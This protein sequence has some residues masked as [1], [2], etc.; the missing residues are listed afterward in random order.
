M[1]I[2]T[3]PGQNNIQMRDWNGAGMLAVANDGK[4][5]RLPL[6]VNRAL[7]TLCQIIL[8]APLILMWAVRR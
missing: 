7:W 2:R 3:G 6:P 5:Y 8:A 1:L 4:A